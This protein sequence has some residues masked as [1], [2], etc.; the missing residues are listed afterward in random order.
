MSKQTIKTKNCIE[1][2]YK[3]LIVIK[4]HYNLA[5]ERRVRKQDYNV[6]AVVRKTSPQSGTPTS[7][8]LIWLNEFR[9][10]YLQGSENQAQ[11]SSVNNKNRYYSALGPKF[12]SPLLWRN[13]KSQRQVFLAVLMA[14]LMAPVLMTP[15]GS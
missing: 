13:Q 14:V 5:V 8:Q 7:F 1:Q 11:T 12:F 3:F 6:F 10:D 2:H 15:P 4:T 9:F